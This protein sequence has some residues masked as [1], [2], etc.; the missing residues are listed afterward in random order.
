MTYVMAD[1][2][3]YYD[4]YLDFL[5]YVHFCDKDMLYII[6]DL[7]DRGSD[8]IQLLQDVMKRKNVVSIMGNHEYML[9]STL[10][11]LSYSDKSS[12]KEIIRNELA[13]M[14]IGQEDTLTDFCR[15]NRKEQLDI[16][17]YLKSLP[18]YQEVIVNSQKH[19]LVHGGLPD[20]S[21]VDIDF[22]SEEEL[23]FGPH[24]FSINH[25]DETIIIVG[26]QPTR[27][28]SGAEADEIFKSN[29]SIAIDCGLGFGG[30]LG[31]ICLETGE[32]LY[33]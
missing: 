30:Q 9:L 31:V 22:Y 20:F 5:H 19:L 13:M 4:K 18:L 33:F 11:E 28:I 32:E 3:G 26:H 25:F 10:E 6:G 1:I 24:D 12:Q 7:I 15:L 23:L 16:I 21:D 2:H 29:D 8:G 17:D 27:F 14:P